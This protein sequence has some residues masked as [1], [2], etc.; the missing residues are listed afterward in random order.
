MLLMLII[1]FKKSIVSI[2]LFILPMLNLNAALRVPLPIINGYCSLC[3]S[4]LRGE[5][6]GGEVR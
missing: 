3:P 2:L 6:V 5:G 1:F 4:T